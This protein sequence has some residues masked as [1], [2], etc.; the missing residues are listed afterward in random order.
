LAQERRDVP[1]KSFP[2]PSAVALLLRMLDK[3]DG[4]TQRDRLKA[5]LP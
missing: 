1:L 5:E 4:L 3:N 2:V